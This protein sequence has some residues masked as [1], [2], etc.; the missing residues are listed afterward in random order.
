M[1]RRP[2]VS[3]PDFLANVRF[4]R[5]VMRSAFGR[6]PVWFRDEWERR[7]LELRLCPSGRVQ[8]RCAKS[9]RFQKFLSE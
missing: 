4:L 8:C 6:A 9:G 7:D 5:G 2:G 1:S 3:E